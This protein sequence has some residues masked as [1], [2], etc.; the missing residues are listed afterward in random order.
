MERERDGEIDGGAREIRKRE[1]GRDGE[2]EMGGR[3]VR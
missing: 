1:G 3:G 2:R